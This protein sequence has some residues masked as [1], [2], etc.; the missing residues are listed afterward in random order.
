[1]ISE[2]EQVGFGSWNRDAPFNDQQVQPEQVDPGAG[3][4]S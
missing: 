1:M 4:M 3:V 2:S